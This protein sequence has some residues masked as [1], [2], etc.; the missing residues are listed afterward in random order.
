[1]K[2]IFFVSISILITGILSGI[3][4]AAPIDLTTGPNASVTASDGSVWRIA[5]NH[6]TGTGVYDPFLR[7]GAQGTEIGLNTDAKHVQVYDDQ[8]G[9]DQWTHSLNWSDVGIVTVNGKQYYDF[10]LDINEADNKIARYLSLDVFRLYAY[11]G[12]LGGSA[13]DVSQLGNPVYDLSSSVPIGPSVLM[14]YHI[15]NQGSGGDDM[16]ALIPVIAGITPSDFLYLYVQFGAYDDNLVR[17]HRDY[18]SD[19]GFEEWRVLQSPVSVP[20]PGTL[21]LFGSALLGLGYFRIKR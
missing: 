15:I 9:G 6:P 2:K 19:A 10:T 14:D 5:N 13:T 21:L 17:C 7:V 16:E 18:S 11:S 1:M 8:G 20:E 3:A 4:I 12:P